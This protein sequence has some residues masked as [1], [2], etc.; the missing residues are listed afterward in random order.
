MTK[1]LS[2]SPRKKHSN[3]PSN[4]YRVPGQCQALVYNAIDHEWIQCLRKIKSG[5]F[6]VRHVGK[7][8]E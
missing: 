3:P 6:C 2:S 4:V 5:K 8:H 7:A 1:Q